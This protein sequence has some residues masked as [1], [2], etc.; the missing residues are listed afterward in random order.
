MLLTARFAFSPAS[1]LR[2][3][4]EEVSG[5]RLGIATSIE[6]LGNRRLHVRFGKMGETL[7]ETNYNSNIAIK[8][9]SNKLL[10]S[11]NLLK[12]GFI[13]PEFIYNRLP[14]QNEYPILVRTS[15]SL[16]GGQ[17]IYPCYNEKEAL[18][19]LVRGSCWCRYIN[20]S[21]EFRFH[22]TKSRF[23][24]NSIARVMKKVP[25]TE[26]VEQRDIHIRHHINYRFS[27]RFSPE[28][29]YPNMSAEILKAIEPFP[30]RMFALDVGW[31][32]EHKRPVFFEANTAPGLDNACA[33]MYAQFLHEEG[34]V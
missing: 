24:V 4:I 32:P 18:S 12:R 22:I 14:R 34:I 33:T 31:S 29:K 3:A 10:M 28:D 19:H 2:D 25:R 1:M 13:A 5:V 27:R 11:T 7:Q 23:G 16:Y 20:T 9:L 6:R 26:E 30:G 15:L 17:G 21:S 8:F